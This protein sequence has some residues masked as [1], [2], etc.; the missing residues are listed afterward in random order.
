MKGVRAAA[1]SACL[2]LERCHGDSCQ[3]EPT[4]SS[5]R[6]L[7]ARALYQSVPSSAFQK[8]DNELFSWGA[9]AYQPQGQFIL[10]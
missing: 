9:S 2:D 10:A 6:A 5:V 3:R 1:F 4:G 8:E 7:A